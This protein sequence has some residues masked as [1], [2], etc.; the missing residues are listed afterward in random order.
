MIIGLEI[1]LLIF[2]FVALI[3]GKFTITKNKVVE[4]MPARLLGALAILPLPLLVGLG[5]LLGLAKGEQFFVKNKLQLTIAEAAIVV[6][7]AIIIFGVGAAIGK[8]PRKQ[9]RC[10]DEIDDDEDDYHYGQK[11]RS[12]RDDRNDRDDDEDED[13]RPKRSRRSLR[14]ED[15]YE[16]DRPRRRSRRDDDDD[17]YDRPRRRDR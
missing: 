3:R 10:R 17:D 11:A 13:D 7:F 8:P 15:E 16:E 9:R 5:I 12:R 4:G 2:G 1:G 14:E 6:V